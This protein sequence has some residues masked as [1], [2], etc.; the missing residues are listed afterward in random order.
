MPERYSSGYYAKVFHVDRRREL[1][2]PQAELVRREVT[3]DR[4]WFAR[5]FYTHKTAK[6]LF[7]DNFIDVVAAQKGWGKR[8]PES[9]LMEFRPTLMSKVAY[10][11]TD[12]AVFSLHMDQENYGGKISLCKCGACQAHRTFHKDNN[13]EVLA[14]RTRDDIAPSGIYVP[15]DYLTDYCLS[16]D[17]K[18]IFF[19]IDGFSPESLRHY[20]EH[21]VG[22]PSIRNQ[23]GDY[24][25]RYRVNLERSQKSHDRN[26]TA[27]VT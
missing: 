12:H 24:L 13:L 20:I 18:I 11:D 19:E 1:R 26:G 25:R 3:S 17:A 6:L 22:S 7:P 15:S 10:V 9:D 23:I 2:F 14:R 4:Y 16:R 5:L 27:V 21:Y 8:N